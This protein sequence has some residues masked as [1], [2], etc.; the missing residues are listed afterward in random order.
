MAALRNHPRRATG[1]GPI[2]EPLSAYG[3]SG[4]HHYFRNL[5]TVA[6]NAEFAWFL[7]HEN[8][9]LPIQFAVGLSDGLFHAARQVYWS[10]HD[11]C[12]EKQDDEAFTH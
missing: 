12:I 11:A 3:A 8:A 7:F 5:R 1:H 10:L 4:K 6:H 9:H 2:K